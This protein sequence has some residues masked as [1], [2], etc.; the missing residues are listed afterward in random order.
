MYSEQAPSVGDL[1][2]AN[3]PTYLNRGQPG[4]DRRLCLVLGL[5]VQ[6]ETNS[7]E[8]LWL[9]R[10]SD[11]M[12]KIRTWDYVLQKNEIVDCNESALRRDYVIRTPRIDLIP[13][14]ERFMDSICPKASVR[15]T[16][17]DHFTP[18]LLKGQH[19]HFNGGSYG[20]REQLPDCVVKLSL[21]DEVSFTRFDVETIIHSV[22]MPPV[23]SGSFEKDNYALALRQQRKHDISVRRAIQEDFCAAV[24]QGDRWDW[25]TYKTEKLPERLR[26]LQLA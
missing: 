14:N 3:L 2:H 4:D 5:E 16:F 8:G 15:P 22:N 21:D 23:H 24:R 18:Q 7:L 11:R 13:A 19:S 1:V 6:A 10:L 25:Q 26:A 20:P 17:W 9:T 12:D